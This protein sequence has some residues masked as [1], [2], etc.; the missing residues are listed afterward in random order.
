[1][2]SIE[3]EAS[4]PSTFMYVLY[5]QHNDEFGEDPSIEYTSHD[6][7]LLLKY[8]ERKY[9]QHGRCVKTAEDQWTLSYSECQGLEKGDGIWKSWISIEEVP[10][11]REE[12]IPDEE[13]DEEQED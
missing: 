11:L 10:I 9:M 6:K 8:V 13:S 3:E 2:S 1:M 12:D 7:K 4:L 5:I